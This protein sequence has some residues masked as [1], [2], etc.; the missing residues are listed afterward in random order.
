LSLSQ[1]EL[2]TTSQSIATAVALRHGAWLPLAE[3][4]SIKPA[5]RTRWK[6]LVLAMAAVDL[7]TIGSAVLIASIARFGAPGLSQGGP[8]GHRAELWVPFYFLG[9]L[10]AGLHSRHRLENPFEELRAI[11]KGITVG[12][13]LAI[14]VSF[15][16]KFEFS[17]GWAVISW[18]LALVLVAVGRYLLRKTVH[19]LRRRG[20]LRRRVV[21]VGTHQPAA[22]LLTSVERAPWEGLDVIGFVAADGDRHPTVNKV[23]GHVSDLRNIVLV[24]GV[25]EVL[26]APEIDAKSVGELSAALDGVPVDLRFAPGLDGFLPSR[27]V[28]HPLGDRPLLAIERAE[29]QPIARIAKRLLDLVLGSVLFLLSL[30]VLAV[31]AAA[32]RIDSKGPVFFRQRRV[33]LNGTEF[34]VWKLRTM[35]ADA[36]SKKA[37]LAHGNE[38]DGVLFKLRSD[39]RVTRVGAFLR[40]V[41]L[42]ELPQLINILTGQMTL[43]GPRPLPAADVARA[44]PQFSRRLRVRPGM[45]GLWQV[46]GRSELS[47][48]D[49]LRLDLLYAQNWSI[50]LDFFILAKTVPVVLFRRGA[51]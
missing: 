30:P 36:E 47:Y 31:C 17:R 8:S 18:V 12:S 38:A 50:A 34:R 16:L 25:E 46:S 32:I 5:K 7:I 45:T 43:V 4:P 1:T 37:A 20:R 41:S 33:G 39:P 2:T 15:S 24:N 13:V 29:L 23:L 35:V 22:R 6:V 44:D 10:T 40:K 48:E 3:K 9:L 21:I 14:T 42:D 51:Y 28:V 49:F 11:V 19:A 26:V 27:I